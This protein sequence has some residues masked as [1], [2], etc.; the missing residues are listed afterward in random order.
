MREALPAGTVTFLVIDIE[1]STRL[2]HALGDAYATTLE[3]YRRLVRSA[4]EEWRGHE[5]SAEGDGFFLAFDRADAAVQV[6]VAIQRQLAQPPPTA[7]GPV[8]VRMGLHT[9]QPEIVDNDYV[10]LDVHRAARIGD[11]GHGGQILMSRATRDLVEAD[12][13]DDLLLRSLGEHWLK[14]IPRPEHVTQLT[15]RGQAE[16]F[17]PLRT[18]GRRVPNLPEQLT[19]FVGREEALKVARLLM[20]RTRLLTLTGS[21]GTGKTRL[22]IQ[23]AAML[24]DQFN[25]GVWFVPLAST[26]EADQ[27]LPSI[28]QVLGIPDLHGRSPV[29]V[30][31]EALCEKRTLLLLDNFE[32]VVEA[33]PQIASVLAGCPHAK[34]LVT[35]RVS[36]RVVG[37]QEL[38]VPPLAL[39]PH[40]DGLVR[41]LTENEAVRLFVERARAVKADFHLTDE[42]ASAVADIC[43]RLDGLPLAIELAAGRIRLLSPAAMLARLGDSADS[44]NGAPRL[45]LLNSGARD[46][47]ERQRTLRST[48][49]WSYNLL[50]PDEQAL[51]R[52]LC[53]F[54][55][56]FT[57][58]SAQA[59]ATAVQV[60]DRRWVAAA[61]DTLERLESLLSK[62]LLRQQETSDREPRFTMLET[63]REYGLEQLEACGELYSMR[64]WHAEY[65]LALAELAEQ[66]LRGQRQTEWIHP[67]ETEHENFRAALEWSL[68][69]PRTD[70]LSL[71]LAASLSWFWQMQAYIGEG[72]GWFERILSRSWPDTSAKAKALIGRSWVA[73]IQRDSAGARSGLIQA[74]AICRELGDRWLE[75]WALHLLGRVEYFEGNA[76][77]AHDLGLQS[78]EAARDTDSPWL[79][80]WAIHLL[81]LA[82]HVVGDFPTAMTYYEESVAIRQELGYMEGVSTCHILMSMIAYRERRLNDAVALLQQALKELPGMAGM[83]A[84]SGLGTATGIAAGLGQ[85]AL[86]ARLLAA[87]RSLSKMTGSAP[88]PLA[89]A[90]IREVD[91]QIAASLGR[92]EYQRCCSEGQSM[93]LPDAIAQ[94]LSLRTVSEP[95]ERTIADS[96]GPRPEVLTARERE[97][98]HLVAK[99]QT[100]REIAEFLVVSLAT[101]ER[102]L[103]HIYGKLGVRGRADAVVWAFRS[104]IAE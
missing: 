87:I 104:G 23:L 72:P 26:V 60:G 24:Q 50:D 76:E 67:L 61:E 7:A 40:V 37:E 5:V 35:S 44:R 33:A 47:S 12:L 71:R 8:R 4:T 28:L 21:G 84:L 101:V 3:A 88:I 66:A 80:G 57:I 74:L 31:Q 38:E 19:T 95:A 27:V 55:G 45:R 90:I 34:V 89:E 99:G 32:Q 6:A 97:I 96:Q 51:Y 103:T 36:L 9:G 64:R 1:R 10:G 94:M 41:S 73:H 92:D 25:D 70:D 62:H 79:A 85:M 83:L 20:S 39:P 58:P 77:A 82:A 30:L 29:N 65:L 81:G 56:G 68:S 52:R 53:I 18:I 54:V 17:P 93:T 49:D 91:E 43:T 42:N 48:I 78:L 98:L 100:S 46:Q 2:L 69:D 16:S 14:D 22:A 59:A 63:I 102:H 86:A 75:G 13:A 15:I 11:A